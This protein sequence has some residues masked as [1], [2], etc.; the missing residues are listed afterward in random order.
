MAGYTSGSQWLQGC[1][2]LLWWAEAGEAADNQILKQEYATLTAEKK[3]LYASQSTAWNFMQEILIA[4]QN[5]QML[6]DY[7]HTEHGRD[8]DRV[9]R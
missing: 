7:H 3:K 1:R 5:V 9:V 2:S 6:L 4:Q 8:S